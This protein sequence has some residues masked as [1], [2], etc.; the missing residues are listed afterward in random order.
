MTKTMGVA[1]IGV[2][3]VGKTYASVFKD[4]EDRLKLVGAMGRS[5][6]TGRGFLDQYDLTGKAYGPGVVFFS[7]YI[8]AHEGNLRAAERLKDLD[9]NFVTVFGGPQTPTY[10]NATAQILE[11]HP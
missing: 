6:E 3:M 1:L 8:W 9:P 7:N 5:L 11:S 10:P 4:S 2:G